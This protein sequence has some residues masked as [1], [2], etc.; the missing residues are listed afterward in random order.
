MI[1]LKSISFKNFGSFGNTPTVIDLTK[2]RM[3]LVSGINGQGKSFALLDTITFALYGKPF[4]KINIPQLVNS[5]NRKDCEVTIEFTAKGRAYKIIRGLAPKR[6]EVYEDGELVDQDST[7]KDYQKRLEDQILHMNYKTFTQVVILGSSS[8]VPFM[9]LSAADRRAVI[10]NIL[11]IEIFSL[12][13]DVVKAKLSTTKEEVKLKKSEIEVMIHKAE[14]QKTFIANVKKQRE[15]FA[16][17]RETK[18]TEYKDK[19]QTLQDN[20][21]KLSGSIAEKTSQLPNHKKI[22]TELENAKGEKKEM[23][24]KAKQINKDIAFLKKNTSCSRCGQDID[25]DHRKTS[26][27][28]LD[29]DLRNMADVFTPVLDTID[30]CGKDLN[31]YERLMSEIQQ[32]QS[33]K[34]KN[35]STCKI[36]QEE[37][38]KFYTK[39]DDDTVLSD[40]QDEL[41]KIREDG[42]KLAEQRDA[43]LE[44]KSNYEIAS[45]LLK[46]SGV[47]AKIIQHFLPL[48]NSLINKYLQAMDFFASFELDEN[49]NETI[50]SRHRDKFSYASFSEGEKLRIDL[51]IL[52]TWREISKLKNSANCNILVLDEVFDSSLDATG[53][54]EFMKLIRFFDKDI[55]IFVIS[56]KA[57]QLV[58]KFERV[59]QFEKKKNFSKMKEDYA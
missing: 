5:V 36:Y 38:D 46:D 6:F 59:M 10:E 8:F 32:E 52:L 40:A 48:I 1:N 54:D 17:E 47:K 58:D 30:K 43:L 39:T 18:I 28:Q 11:D 27:D 35:E 33:Q 42:G 19:I 45:V 49:F 37:L 21:T 4:R 53:M 41:E 56:H 22:I 15:E 23:E 34:D 57:D 44:D 3:N 9:Q 51:A 16:D 25:E 13:N 31:E 55:N 14:N 2:R 24:T 7:A 50:K 26:I 20:S 29:A 12:M